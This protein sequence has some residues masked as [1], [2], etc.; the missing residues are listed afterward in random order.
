MI[1]VYIYKLKNTQDTLILNKVD[2][3]DDV[4]AVRIYICVRMLKRHWL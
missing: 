4:H 3:L 1:N 2:D